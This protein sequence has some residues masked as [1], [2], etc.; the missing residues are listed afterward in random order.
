MTTQTNTPT[1]TTTC[2]ACGEN[3]SY[4]SQNICLACD[5]RSERILI[6]ESAL[7]ELKAIERKLNKQHAAAENMTDSEILDSR[8]TNKRLLE[9]HDDLENADSAA[10]YGLTS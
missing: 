9:A 6:I 2:Q 3:P 5:L 8:R 10:S 1:E 7:E 4:R